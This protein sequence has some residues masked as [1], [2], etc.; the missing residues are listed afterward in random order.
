M[1]HVHHIQNSRIPDNRTF[2]LSIYQLCC[3]KGL[4]SNQIREGIHKVRKKNTSSQDFKIPLQGFLVLQLVKDR[5][6]RI[7]TYNNNKK[8]VY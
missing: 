6:A 1:G 2:S 3:F 8:A 7:Y 5:G 4:Q